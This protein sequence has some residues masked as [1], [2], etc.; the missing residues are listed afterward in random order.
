MSTRRVLYCAAVLALVLPLGAADISYGEPRELR[1]ATK[2]YIWQTDP[3]EL[4]TDAVAELQ[5][6]VPALQIVDSEGEADI[7][8]VI[9]RRSSEKEGETLW[10]TSGMVVRSISPTRS[11]ILLE[12]VSKEADR[13]ASVKEVTDALI[14]ELQVANGDRYG[15][16]E[17]RY[18]ADPR[19]P[20]FRSTAGLKA[21]MSKKEVRAALGPPTKLEGKGG[22]T[23]IWYYETT[24]GATRLVFAGDALMHVKLL[25][26]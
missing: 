4:R 11:R 6:R 2:L 10:V 15:K 9:K 24:D 21:G 12:P 7:V 16:A 17:R 25:E 20:R 13:S 26:K 5:E 1:G 18:P 8:F 19:A 22:R 3:P 23:T 14:H